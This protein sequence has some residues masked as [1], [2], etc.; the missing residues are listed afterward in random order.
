MIES[1]DNMKNTMSLPQAIAVVAIT[2]L[3]CVA[4]A[5]L[6][7][8]LVSISVG[9][10]RTTLG[11]NAALPMFTDMLAS[12]CMTLWWIPILAICVGAPLIVRGNHTTANL[13]VYVTL[14]GFL[15]LVLTIFT[16]VAMVL[17]WVPMRMDIGS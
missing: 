1:N 13:I 2:T 3:G 8:G 14:F 16:V 9:G 10:M 15:A 11:E 7:S 5:W 12:N 17:P 4:A 6:L